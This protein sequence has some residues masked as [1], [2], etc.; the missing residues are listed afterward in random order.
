MDDTPAPQPDVLRLGQLLE[1]PGI[2][3][4][5]EPWY[6]ARR[7]VFTASEVSG[8]FT[9]SGALEVARKKWRP[10]AACYDSPAIRWGVTFECVAQAL[11]SSRTARRVHEFGLLLHPSGCPLGA[12]PD[13]ITEDGVMLEIKCPFTRCITPDVP[14]AYWHQVQAQLEVAGLS[15]CDFLECRFHIYADR[16]R[17]LEDAAPG[18]PHLSDSSG[19]E[20]GA[21]LPGNAVVIE[22]PQSSALAAFDRLGGAPGPGEPF[23]SPPLLWRLEV[24][25]VKQ[26]QR[27]RAFGRRLLDRVREVHGLL[28]R[29]PPPPKPSDP[30]PGT[31]PPFAFRAV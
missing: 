31:L 19:M 22:D 3:Q 1:N 17:Y 26:I 15:R 10:R 4:R 27:D 13:G 7:R 6:E 14:S 29:E 21:L 9:D 18:Q 23:P 12:S 28:E 24:Y 20:R 11:Y 25:D 5:T 30:P 8:I 2:P 16:S